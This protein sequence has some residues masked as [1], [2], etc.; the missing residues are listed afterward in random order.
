MTAIV[1]T[2]NRRG[3][4]FA[5]DSAATYTTP[6]T[7]KITND[8]NKIFELSKKHPVGIA[9]YNNLDFYGIPWEVIIKTYRDDFLKATSF[10]HLLDYVNSF[11]KYVQEFVL[12]K[13]PVAEQKSLLAFFI[14]RLKDELI[15]TAKERLEQKGIETNSQNI[16]AEILPVLSKLSKD[17]IKRN[18][19][20][21]FKKYKKKQLLEYGEDIID[22]ILSDMLHDPSCPSNFK[23]RFIDAL[24]KIITADALVYLT[25]T[26]LVFWGYGEDEL[27]PSYYQY[28]VT[29]TIDGLVKYV[30]INDYEVSNTQN[31]CV[32]PFA[33]TDVAN[34]VVRGI[35]QKLRDTINLNIVKSFSNFRDCIVNALNSAG[36]PYELLAALNNLNI[37][38]QADLFIRDTN[39]FISTNY[40]NKLLETVAFL[41]KEDLADMAESL[42]RMTCLKRHITTDE[43]SV[44]G[45][46]DVAVITKGDGFVWIKRKN[47][48][49]AELN[50]H[51]FERQ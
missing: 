45:P 2:L 30:K 35:D 38:E 25:H 21:A 24:Y 51:Y 16:F 39:E 47:Y 26:G 22:S 18:R 6:T 27:F 8:A 31:A 12:P 5:A 49:P 33:Q 1:G 4:A 14:Q 7:R 44:G 13:I 9:I 40:T 17:Y 19:T 32:V 11:W 42:V 43:E 15:F 20:S 23:K 46:V 29:L 48:F 34:T 36:A 28:E 10:P 41:S 37:N 50:N 3:V